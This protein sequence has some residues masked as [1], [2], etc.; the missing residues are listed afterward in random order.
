MHR[1]VQLTQE[2]EATPVYYHDCPALGKDTKLPRALMADSKGEY[3]LYYQ[4]KCP[5]CS[6][7]GGEIEYASGVTPT[8]NGYLI[9]PKIAEKLHN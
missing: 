3:I 2:L 1:G 8:A 4:H 9:D 6:K 7:T 5:F